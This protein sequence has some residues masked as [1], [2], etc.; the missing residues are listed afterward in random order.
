MY[1]RTA[2]LGSRGEELDNGPQT[3]WNLCVCNMTISE[4]IRWVVKH[5]ITAFTWTAS[6]CWQIYGESRQSGIGIA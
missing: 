4:V 1:C 6:G 5:G 3:Q 2:I